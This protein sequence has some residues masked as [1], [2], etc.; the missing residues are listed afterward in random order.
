MKQNQFSRTEQL[1]YFILSRLPFKKNILNL[2]NKK[3]LSNIKKSKTPLNLVYY[4]TNNCNL[5]CRHCF[6]W[7]SLNKNN[8][9]ELNQDELTK[10]AK[11][12]KHPLNVLSIT[13]GEPFLRKDIVEVCS[14]FYKYNNTKR[15]NITTNGFDSEFI[16][17]S[18]K[19]ILNNNPR[20]RLTIFISLD[21]MEDTH[22]KIRNNKNAFAK[23][24]ETI[25]RL[26]QIN[27]PNLSL[28]I[29]TT[30][31]KENFKELPELIRYLKQ[32][33]IIHKFN[34]LRN[35]SMVSCVDKDLTYNFSPQYFHPLEKEELFQV[36][37]LIKENITNLSSKV[38]AL[39]IRNSIEIIL[40]KTSPVRCLATYTDVVLFPEGNI[41]ICE[42]TKIF[43]NIRN[44]DYDFYRLWNSEETKKVKEKLSNCKCIQPEN[45]LNS[46]K[47]DTETLTKVFSRKY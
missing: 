15:I 5:R 10:I 39:K 9:N 37:S 38:E 45:L 20:K 30:I 2:L 42:P 13:G 35:S 34:L 16:Y 44:Y 40:N 32:F 17:E 18:V 12:L 26:K 4:I 41:S 46:M 14:I 22:N 6:Y 47:Y 25:K 24:T 29:A 19:R 33:N 7:K 1:G 43:T 11:S 21:G 36:Y 8:K 28:L 31:Y 27:N 23:V 3:R